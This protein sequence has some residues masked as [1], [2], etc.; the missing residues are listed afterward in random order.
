[1]ATWDRVRSRP[2]RPAPE[3]LIGN[4]GNVEIASVLRLLKQRD[5]RRILLRE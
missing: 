2:A 1:M 5:N 4:D 3:L